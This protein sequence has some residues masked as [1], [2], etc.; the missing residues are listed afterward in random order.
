MSDGLNSELNPE[1]LKQ[2]RHEAKLEKK[3]WKVEAKEREHERKR[4][5][6]EMGMAVTQRRKPSTGQ[7]AHRVL[8]F[9]Q[10]VTPWWSGEEVEKLIA[11]F[12]AQCE[13]HQ[14][15]G[16]CRVGREGVNANLSG[17]PAAVE[18]LV[19][20]SRGHASGAFISTDF[21]IAPVEDEAAFQKLLVWRVAEICSLGLDEAAQRRLAEVEPG[22][23]LTPEQW[24]EE[25]ASAGEETVL[26]DTRNMYETRI[27]RFEGPGEAPTVDPQCRHFSDLP[28]WYEKNAARLKEK[29][30]MMYCTGGVR[31]EKASAMLKSHGVEQVYQLYGGVERYL[32][33]YQDGGHFKGSLYVFDKSQIAGPGR[34]PI[35]TAQCVVCSEPWEHYQGRNPR[36]CAKCKTLVLVCQSCV[37][38]GKDTKVELACGLPGCSDSDATRVGRQHAA[39]ATGAPPQ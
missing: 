15:L 4:K 1:E 39:G 23:H 24:H 7:E 9:Y 28:Q 27:G 31:C 13:T 16:R 6:S 12:Q 5:N 8:L 38:S 33:R 34:E 26:L 29:R 25:L 32:E 11:W 2:K 22:T 35:A 20:A 37:H 17:S 21:K 19:T 10:Y 30:V 14:V 18:A 36:R 3:K